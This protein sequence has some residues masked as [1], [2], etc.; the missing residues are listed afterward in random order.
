MY[1]ALAVLVIAK[2]LHRQRQQ[3]RFFFGEHGRHLA[4]GGAM[5]AR[6]R[7]TRLPVIQVSLSFLQAFEAQPFQRRFLS[8]SNT[9]FHFPF[10]IWIRYATWKCDG[11]IMAQHVMV[12]RIERGIID[13]RSEYAFAQVI[14]HHHTRRTSEPAKSLFM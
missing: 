4:L 3:R 11:A 12:E 13:V 7:P 5:N 6:V 2:G 9:G 14:E 8:M 1:G 10:P